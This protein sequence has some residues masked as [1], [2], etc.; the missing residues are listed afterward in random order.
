MRV[1]EIIE[2]M[3][4]LVPP[5][6]AMD[7]DHS[8]L[9]VGDREQEVSRVYISLDC[10]DTAVR[11]AEESSCELILTHHPLLFKPLERLCEQDFKGHRIREL[12]RNNISCFAM[13]T[14]YDVIRMADRNAR[15]FH[16][17]DAVLLMEAGVRDGVPYGFG[18]VG[19]LREPMTL[20]DYA[21]M[22]KKA[23]LLDEIRVYGDPDRVI[24]RAAVASGAGKS[25]LQDALLKGAQVLVTGDLDYH[26]ATDAV[27]MGI[28]MIDAG[29]YGTEYCFIDET[30]EMLKDVLPSLIV[31]K[32]SEEQPYQIL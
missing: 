17:M 8:G 14:N 10:D 2:V 22:V 3:D 23:A 4:R 21:E 5:Y 31:V 9:Q 24:T 16:I 19:D 27:S 11:E 15:D 29:H 6:Y 1:G 26:T 13:H 32:R 20:R 12:V 28:C 18:R 30:A 25:A 7:W